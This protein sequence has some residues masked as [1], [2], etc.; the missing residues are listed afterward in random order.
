MSITTIVGLLLLSGFI[1]PAFIVIQK[2]RVEKKKLE[3]F[4][5]ELEKDKKIRISEHETWKNKILGIDLNSHIAIFIIRD[6]IRNECHIIDLH[7]ISGCSVEKT[8]VTSEVD[9]SIQAVDTIRLRFISRDKSLPD[10]LFSLFIEEEDQTLGAELRIA[11]AWALKFNASL[12][13]LAKAA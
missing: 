5:K 12:R 13:K 3:Q 6:K 10:Q 11:E 7:G 1:I 8:M 2:Q 9:S 4:L